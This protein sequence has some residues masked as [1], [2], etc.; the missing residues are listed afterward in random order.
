MPSQS[1]AAAPAAVTA[2]A[3]ASS[4]S[5]KKGGL[6]LRR[7]SWLRKSPRENDGTSLKVGGGNAPQTS[8]NVPPGYIGAGNGGVAGGGGGG[9]GGGT[10]Q[11]G[12]ETS[13]GGIDV[14]G[15]WIMYTDAEGFQYC[16]NEALQESR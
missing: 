5:S 2:V 6:S 11:S 4:K 12:V 1:P 15:G 14:G 16:W 7:R 13:C 10:S 9:G 3:T 8:E